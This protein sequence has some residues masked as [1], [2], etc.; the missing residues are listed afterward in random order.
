MISQN[1]KENSKIEINLKLIIII[2]NYYPH[3]IIKLNILLIHLK[4]ILVLFIPLYSKI[5]VKL[6]NLIKKHRIFLV[7]NKM[8]F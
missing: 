7:M 4:Q 6:C 1:N 5:K 8:K 2:I 3:K